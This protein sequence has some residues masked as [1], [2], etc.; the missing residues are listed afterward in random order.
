MARP[1][2]NGKLPMYISEIHGSYWLRLPG[3]KPEK[4]CRVTDGIAKVTEFL[5]KRNVTIA[6]PVKSGPVMNHYFAKFK[7]EMLGNS[8]PRTQADQ[9]RHFIRL[10]AHFG[11]MEPK[12]VT[13]PIISAYLQTKDRG[14]RQLNQEVSTLSGVFRAMI[15]IW[16]VFDHNPTL[17]VTRNKLPRK[18]RYVTDAEFHAVRSLAIP[19]MAVAMDL[20][21]K[22]GQRLGDLLRLKWDDISDEGIYFHQGKTG[23]EVIIKLNREINGILERARALGRDKNG[24][25]KG[26]GV[27]VLQ[28][29][30]GSRYHPHGFKANWLRLQNLAVAEGAI[31]RRYKF[32]HLR[33]KMISDSKTLHEAYTR[34]GHIDIRVTRG[35]YDSK[36]RSIEALG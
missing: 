1:K 6:G 14:K 7:L 31:K 9:L 23:A 2:K 36:P 12:E 8:A 35:I 22:T 19:V 27:Y 25:P 26:D 32:H 29:R 10:E 21:L 18:K 28:S 33:N 17:G 24:K 34:A 16:H 15:E 30:L 5:K 4:I 13:P 3:T 11:D 20:G